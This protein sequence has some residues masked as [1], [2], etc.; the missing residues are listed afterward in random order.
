MLLPVLGWRTAQALAD[1]AKVAILDQNETEAEKL[2]KTSG[3]LAAVCGVADAKSAESALVRVEKELGLPRV[4]VHCPGIGPAKRIRG[5][6]GPMAIGDLARAIEVDL[7]GAFK[8][9]RMVA[10]AMARAKTMRMASAA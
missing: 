1:G 8:I 2:A 3:D 9:F 7:I 6:E 5:R 10:A 4:C